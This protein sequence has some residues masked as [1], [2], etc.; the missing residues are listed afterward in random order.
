ML[1]AGTAKNLWA[2]CYQPPLYYVTLHNVIPGC[3]VYSLGPDVN[4]NANSVRG[5][6]VMERGGKRKKSAGE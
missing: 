4:Q 2:Q 6:K 3:P 1:V 5:G